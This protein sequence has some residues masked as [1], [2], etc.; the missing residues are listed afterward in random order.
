MDWYKHTPHVFT[1]VKVHRHPDG[2]VVV[3]FLMD[4]KKMVH[5][6][7]PSY[8][9]DFLSTRYGKELMKSLFL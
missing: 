4:G 9:R 2:T 7:T 5:M 8:L 3:M 6:G 1:D